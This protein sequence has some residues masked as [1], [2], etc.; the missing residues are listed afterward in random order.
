VLNGV[1][2]FTPCPKKKAAMDADYLIVTIRPILLGTQC[3]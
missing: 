1:E 3:K 2:N